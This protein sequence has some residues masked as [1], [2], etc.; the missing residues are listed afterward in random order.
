MG[1]LGCRKRVG[2]SRAGRSGG[3][4]L[5]VRLRDDHEARIGVDEGVEGAA[6]WGVDAVRV[7]GGG[8]HRGW[9]HDAL[10][11][12]EAQVNRGGHAAV[13]LDRDGI[14]VGRGHDQL[15]TDLRGE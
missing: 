10:V 13:A 4:P 15:G 14:L 7:A 6:K 3:E 2:G 12:D 11:V 1:R 9:W 5:E 8:A